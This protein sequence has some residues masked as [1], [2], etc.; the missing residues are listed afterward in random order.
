MRQTHVSG[1]INEAGNGVTS[2]LAI[3]LTHSGTDHSQTHRWRKMDSNFGFRD[4]FAPPTV[5]SQGY[6]LFRQ[7]ATAVE[8]PPNNRRL[9]RAA[10]RSDERRR[11]IGPMSDGASNRLAVWRG[12]RVRALSSGR[13]VL[14]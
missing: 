7:W 14:F 6:R 10:N 8:W 5:R 2:S 3:Q 11:S 4:A 1:L 9:A 12:Q 13:S